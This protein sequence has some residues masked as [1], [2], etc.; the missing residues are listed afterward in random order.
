[1]IFHVRKY[2]ITI[3]EDTDITNI[4]QKIQSS[5]DTEQIKI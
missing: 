1:M 4:L 2:F 5:I 3:P